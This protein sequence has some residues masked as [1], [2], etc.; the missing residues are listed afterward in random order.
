MYFYDAIGIAEVERVFGHY[1]TNGSNANG[2]FL[3]MEKPNFYSI[4]TADVRYSTELN[5]FQKILISEITALTYK[6]G[7][8]FAS[9]SYFAKTFNKS[10][11]SISRNISKI[12]KLGFINIEIDTKKG[13]H[14]RIYLLSNKSIP[15][16]T[17]D[18]R[19][20][21][22]NDKTYNNTSINNIINKEKNTKKEKTQDFEY[23]NLS[24]VFIKKIHEFL[25]Y[26]KESKKPLRSKKSIQSK[27]NS[28]NKEVIQ[29]GEKL[30]IKSIDFSIENGYQGTNIKWIIKNENNE[31]ATNN[32]GS[33][34]EDFAKSIGAKWNPID[35]NDPTH[36]WFFKSN[37]NGNQNR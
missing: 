37:Q 18:K 32:K 13:N 26:R 16:N 21:N 20:I 11:V 24:D 31:N 2:I 35:E 15:I 12:K 8:C 3:Y 9:N 27:I 19:G 5:D 30:V 14:R 6:H 25:Q 17:N 23:H 36:A 22:T 33:I 28:W 7:F 29:H 4:L 10:V 1:L 34:Y